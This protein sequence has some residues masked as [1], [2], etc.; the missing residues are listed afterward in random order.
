[1]LQV[2][3]SFVECIPTKTPERYVS[4]KSVNSDY[5]VCLIFLKVKSTQLKKYAYIYG[6]GIIIESNVLKQF[7]YVAEQ[8]LTASPFFCAFLWL[9]CFTLIIKVCKM[10]FRA[11]VILCRCYL[12]NEARC[13]S[14]NKP[15]SFEAGE[16]NDQDFLHPWLE[17]EHN[18]CRKQ[19]EDKGF[20]LS[21]V[22]IYWF[23]SI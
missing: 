13:F 19:M 22:R 21:E 3:C 12:S 6:F 11:D 18:I 1:M 14:C 16:W 8:I 9:D 4:D 20:V 10:T 5:K 15:W 17:M 2:L 23:Q 7:V